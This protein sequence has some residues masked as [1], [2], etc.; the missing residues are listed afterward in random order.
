MFSGTVKI[1]DLNDY[2]KPAEECVV[3]TKGKL[4]NQDDIE[5]P[6]L[7]KEK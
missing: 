5:L 4:D 1:L 7:I 6:D 2:I 3:M